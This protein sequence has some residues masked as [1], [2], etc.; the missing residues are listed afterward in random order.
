MPRGLPFEPGLTKPLNRLCTLTGS[1][2]GR[3]FLVLK[4]IVVYVDTFM[5]LIFLYR[6]APRDYKGDREGI[7]HIHPIPWVI[8]LELFLESG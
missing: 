4:N 8:R 1:G 5:L 2:H 6:Y 3:E 7:P